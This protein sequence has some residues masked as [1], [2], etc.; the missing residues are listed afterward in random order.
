MHCELINNTESNKSRN[1]THNVK[2]RAVFQK[3]Y[4][5]AFALV[6]YFYILLYF[7][8]KYV[9]RLISKNNNNEN[10]FIQSR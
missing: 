9:Y 5:P 4:A 2:R 1:K 8:L 10:G 7:T 3:Q 6:S